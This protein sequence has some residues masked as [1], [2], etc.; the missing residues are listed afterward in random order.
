M[1][2]LFSNNKLAS[3]DSARTTLLVIGAFTLINLGVIY[4]DTYF[5]FSAYAPFWL[6]LVGYV[7][8]LQTGN[9]ANMV[10][11][12]GIA[13]LLTAPYFVCFFLSKRNIWWAIGGLIYFVADTVWLL[14]DFG[15]AFMVDD[16]SL[17]GDV[18]CHVIA[19]VYCLFGLIPALK[20]PKT[21]DEQN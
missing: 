19:I 1:A 16:F 9:V 11:Y 7:K 5:L 6:N 17:V 12:I 10:L 20:K 2:K 21:D 18:A 4:F 8:Y 15:T 13:A 3:Y 14:I